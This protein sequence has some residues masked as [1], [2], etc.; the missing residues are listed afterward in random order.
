VAATARQP[1]GKLDGDDPEEAA[2][3]EA[4]L[5][6]VVRISGLK[7]GKEKRHLDDLLDEVSRRFSLR[8]I[9]YRSGTLRVPKRRAGQESRRCDECRPDERSE[10]GCPSAALRLIECWRCNAPS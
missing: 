8:A 9:R 6:M 7:G 10:S 2:Q 3:A 5:A 4:L 1:K